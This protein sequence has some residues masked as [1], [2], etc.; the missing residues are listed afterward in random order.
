[1]MHQSRPLLMAVI[2]ASAWLLSACSTSFATQVSG[3]LKT[4]VVFAFLDPKSGRSIS[5]KL[6]VFSAEERG[7]SEAW[8]PIWY[9]TGSQSVRTVEYGVLPTGLTERHAASALAPNRVY[10]VSV[11][12]TRGS[13]QGYSVA[14]FRIDADG[15][16]V[17]LEPEDG[18]P[19]RANGSVARR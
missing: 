1:M 7:E 19:G 12:A 13:A 16:A 8:N 4:G 14:Q 5:V 18:A 11:T 9:A 2:L 17:Q 10:R 15:K 3:D 6:R